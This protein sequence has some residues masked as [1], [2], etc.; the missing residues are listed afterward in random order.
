VRKVGEDKLWR[1]PS[2]RGMFNVRSFYSVLGCNDGFPFPWKSVWQIKVPLRVAFFA[3]S[4]ALGKI[5]TMDNLKKRYII[6]VGRCCMCKRNG[7]SVEYLL[8]H[9]EVANASWNVFFSQFELSL[10][11]P[12]RVVD[13]YTCW[14][15]ARST[16]SVIV[17]KIVPS[18]L[19]WCL[20]RKMSDRSFEDR[21]KTLDEI[22]SFL[23]NF[24][25]FRQLLF[26]S[27]GD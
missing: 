19:L 27:F 11:M 24:C 2:N 13:L 10:V 22:V 20:Y 16:W 7:E 26:F 1:V 25:F 6:V 15:T 17:W 14:W 9:C 12:R 23:Q 8:L 21:K 18:C 3:W 4:V 5:Y